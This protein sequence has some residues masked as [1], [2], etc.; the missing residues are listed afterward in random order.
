MDVHYQKNQSCLHPRYVKKPWSSPWSESSKDM[1]E[2]GQNAGNQSVFSL[3]SLLTPLGWPKGQC[4]YLWTFTTST[5]KEQITNQQNLEL[6]ANTDAK[7]EKQS[8][9]YSL[10]LSTL[11]PSKRFSPV[12][13]TTAGINHRGNRQPFQP[14]CAVSSPPSLSPTSQASL[15]GQKHSVLAWSS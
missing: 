7:E 14:Y 2:K 15:R 4:A 8:L 13:G 6:W 3:N 5:S 11:K 12:T 10:P 9:Y 1:V